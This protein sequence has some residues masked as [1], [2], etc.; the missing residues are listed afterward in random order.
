LRFSSDAVLN[1]EQT[2]IARHERLIRALELRR[3]DAGGAKNHQVS[4]AAFR[5]TLKENPESR[6]SQRAIPCLDTFV[7]DS[8]SLDAIQDQDNVAP[9]TVDLLRKIEI[10]SPTGAVCRSIGFCQ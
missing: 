4:A 10:C 5:C 7:I 8:Y 6:N 9:G 2:E 1:W 3:D